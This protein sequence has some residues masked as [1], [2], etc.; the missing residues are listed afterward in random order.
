M[1]DPL[2][3]FQGEPSPTPLLATY[4]AAIE[5]AV[6]DAHRRLLPAS[7]LSTT[8]QLNQRDTCVIGLRLIPLLPPYAIADAFRIPRA[9]LATRPAGLVV[10]GILGVC[11]AFAA[12]TV[13][14]ALY[15]WRRLLLFAQAQ[16]ISPLDT[17]F[18]TLTVQQFLAA[19]TTTARRKP[20]ATQGG[21]TAAD[22]L[23]KGLHWLQSH[24]SV[25]VGVDRS[26]I[27]TKPAPS[28]PP[29]PSISV[30]L[31]VV[32]RL[33]RV[34]GDTTH[35]DIIR[36]VA[37]GFV[38][39]AFACSRFEH[40]QRTTFNT[41]LHAALEGVCAQRKHPRRHLQNARLV[42]LPAQGLLGTAWLQ[43]FRRMASHNGAFVLRDFEGP[44]LTASSWTDRPLR[45]VRAD[46]AL[47]ALLTGPCAMDASEARLCTKSSFRHFLPE[48]ARARRIP[49]DDRNLIGD[50]T[51]TGAASDAR[52][53]RRRYHPQPM[54]DRYAAGAGAAA[55][56]AILTAQIAAARAI[57]RALGV[58]AL[59]TYTDASA[60]DARFGIG[61]V[62][63]H[64]TGVFVVSATPPP[65]LLAYIRAHAADRTGAHII[66]ELE[67][68]ALIVALRTYARLISD[69]N[70]LSYIDS[71][72]AKSS[73]ISGSAASRGLSDLTMLLQVRLAW[74]VR[75]YWFE[76]IASSV[77]I[78]DAPSRFVPLPDLPSAYGPVHYLDAI[79]P[80]TSELTD[81]TTAI[82]RSHQ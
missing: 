47:Q 3:V 58:D 61:A 62:L 73:A 35:S 75:D 9:Q 37:A 17:G 24:F 80:P 16:Q 36:G 34:A 57:V 31:G 70:I 38:A 71:V 4:T 6:E 65:H 23:R 26:T 41:S 32:A 55:T 19:A 54:A 8:L 69:S 22:N 18:D 2:T 44:L 59:P 63:F 53:P 74:G 76:Y 14:D 39:L 42:W 49:L 67:L 43:P 81:P 66:N 60:S 72:V 77:N 79:W 48:I 12:S 82:P 13:R 29:T 10:H 21:A 40:M 11:C 45:G 30:P 51:G 52:T 46:R 1:A 56:T 33:E 27:I 64:P 7:A 50:W 68:L 78:A 5:E 28:P 15:A 25:Q 20:T